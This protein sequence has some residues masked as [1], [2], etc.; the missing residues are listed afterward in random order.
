MTVRELEE[1]FSTTSKLLLGEALSPVDDYGEWLSR[2]LG[3]RSVFPSAISGESVFFREQFAFHRIAPKKKIISFGDREE[4]GK[5]RIG[6]AEGMG[7]A[8]LLGKIP[9]IAY[10]C[11]DERIKKEQ[12][13][14]ETMGMEDTINCYK[15]NDAFICKNVAYSFYTKIA[16]Y[17][18]GSFRA[19]ESKHCMNAYNCWRSKGLFEC[20]SVKDSSSLYFCHN[21]ENCHESMFC[22]NVKNLRHAIGNVGVGREKY[23][24]VKGMLLGHI[25]KELK[26]KHSLGIDIFNV[27][28]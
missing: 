25:L 14:E 6:G 18:F 3:K 8:E 19:I 16:E 7:V 17:I 9:G 26:E 12:N 24:E 21:V 15:T 1:A 13:N 23:L 2:H 5:F 22:S 20:D 10:F 4:A 27:G 28:K 11:M